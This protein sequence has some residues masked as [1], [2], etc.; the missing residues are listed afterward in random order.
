[1]TDRY[2]LIIFRSYKWK[3]KTRYKPYFVGE[4]A[5]SKRADDIVLDIPKGV[6]ITGRVIMS[7]KTDQ[8]RN[9]EDLVTLYTSAADELGL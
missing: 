1:M 5:K 7:P 9:H 6:S 3:G 4:A 2:D 8:T